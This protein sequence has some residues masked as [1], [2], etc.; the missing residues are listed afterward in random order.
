MSILDL[1]SQFFIY[2][3]YVGS[4][5]GSVSAD[6]LRQYLTEDCLIESNEIKLC[7]NLD[8]FTEYLHRMRAKY[9]K[10]EYS[11]FVHEPLVIGER[12]VIHFL[13]YCI[14]T[15]G[16]EQTLDAI[17]YLKFSQG[18]ISHWK[19][20]YKSSSLVPPFNLSTRVLISTS[21]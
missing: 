14:T 9:A 3:S 11:P 15:D 13:V 4:P 8:E 18:K 21:P 6:E 10:V 2:L 20:V 5:E 19:E 7:E 1:L 17:A 12:V 16:T